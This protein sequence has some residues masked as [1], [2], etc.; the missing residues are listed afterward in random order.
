LK[1]I[2]HEG[3][4]LIGQSEV[5]LIRVLRTNEKLSGL[6]NNVPVGEEAQ[7]G[8]SKNT[9]WLAQL[10]GI[11]DHEQGWYWY[12]SIFNHNKYD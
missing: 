5:Y 1:P 9:D 12:Y 11:Y 3:K 4:S 2:I 10:L 8:H 7:N 6:A